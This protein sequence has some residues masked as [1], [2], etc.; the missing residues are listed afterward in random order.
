M[1]NPVEVTIKISVPAP[2]GAVVSEAASA[3]VPAEA[4]FETVSTEG[5][6]VPQPLEQLAA[7]ASE[8]ISAPGG[9]P[10]PE[11]LAAIEAIAGVPS[12]EEI[13][14]PQELDVLEAKQAK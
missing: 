10:E 7:A 12:E 2:E 11:P 6:P 14:E 3:P 1:N 4:V 13:P 5:L 8:E 9:I